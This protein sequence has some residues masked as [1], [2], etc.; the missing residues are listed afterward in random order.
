MITLLVSLTV[1]APSPAIAPYVARGGEKAFKLESSDLVKGWP[2]GWGA[3][4]QTALAPAEVERVFLKRSE[5]E[6][7]QSGNY[8]ARVII[9]RYAFATPDEATRALASFRAQRAAKPELYKA[10]ERAWVDGATLIVA[11]TD[12]AMFTSYLDAFAP[13]QRVQ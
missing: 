6:P 4:E 8:F 2:K 10:P 5:K 1:L 7:K 3:L 12:A 11:H 13:P 9:E